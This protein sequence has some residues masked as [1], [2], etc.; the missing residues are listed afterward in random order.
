MEGGREGG[1]VEGLTARK[2]S[3]RTG[4]SSC[5]SQQAKQSKAKQ[6][7]QQQNQEQQQLPA[8]LALSA[9]HMQ[10]RCAAEKTF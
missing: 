9:A 10:G 4:G 7:P 3:V 8:K 6:A 2:E 5:S 1:G